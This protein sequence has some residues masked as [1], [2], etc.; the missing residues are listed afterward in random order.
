MRNSVHPDH[1]GPENTSARG[2]RDSAI[3]GKDTWI[4]PEETCYPNGGFKRRCRAIIEG[5]EI[6]VNLRCGIAD[7]FFTI[8]TNSGGFVSIRGG[9]LTYKPPRGE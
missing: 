3:F 9:V 7:T 5:T 2:C 8:P 1:M 4:D 6:Y